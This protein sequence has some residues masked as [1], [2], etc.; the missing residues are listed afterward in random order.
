MQQSRR[1]RTSQLLEKRKK[2]GGISHEPEDVAGQ[3]TSGQDLID[4]GAQEVFTV[5][6]QHDL[7][8]DGHLGGQAAQGQGR[9]DVLLVRFGRRKVFGAQD[10]NDPGPVRRGSGCDGF[11][12]WIAGN[13]IHVVPKVE[14]MFYF[15]A[16]IRG[17]GIDQHHGMFVL[18]CGFFQGVYQI[19]SI[20][21]PA[22]DD[23]MFRELHLK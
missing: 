7:G 12:A 15:I 16:L 1:V 9:I 22:D 18:G 2:C 19:E 8:I 13:E 10:V 5:V 3:F 20:G 21:I 4:A 17:Q 14:F 6:G 23:H 11:I